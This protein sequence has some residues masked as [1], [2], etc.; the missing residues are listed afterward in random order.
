MFKKILIANRGEI[1]RR[2]NRTCHK[3]GIDTVA[4]YSDADKDA[5]FVREASEAYYIGESEAQ[6]SYLDV[7]KII[8]V[9]KQSGA[10]AVHPGYGFLSENANFKQSLTESNITFIG[11][12]HKALEIMGSK[13]KAKACMEAA[14]VPI[15][16]GYHGDNQDDAF[17]Q[18]QA[19]NI[20][21]PVLIKAVSGGGGKGMRV[22]E[23]EADFLEALAGAKRE[24]LNS[25]NDATVLLE[26]FL[27]TPRHIEVQVFADSHGNVVHLFERDCSVQRRHQKIIE[28]APAQNLSDK[29]LDT[30]Y[31]AAINAAKACDYLGAGTIE[32]LVEGENV[33]FMEMNTRLQ[34]EHPVTEMITGLD[35]VEWQLLV[36]NGALLPRAQEAITQSG[37]AIEVRLYAEDC[38]KDFLPQTGRV[39]YLRYPKENSH[40]R[41]DGG[42]VQGSEVSIYY[43]PMIAKLITHAD[44]REQAIQRM[45]QALKKLCLSGLTHNR[46]YLLKCLTHPAFMSGDVDIN[47][48]KKH[49][50]FEAPNQQMSIIAAAISLSL[51]DKSNALWQSAGPWRL[52]LPASEIIDLEYDN[53]KI[54][55][56][57][58]QTKSGYQVEYKDEKIELSAVDE[59]VDL[60]LTHPDGQYRCTCIHH[61]SK[62]TVIDA[63][64]DITFNIPSVVSKIADEDQGQLSAPM[65]GNVIAILCSETDNVEKGQSLMVIEAMKM[66]HTIKSP[67]TGKIDEIFFAIGAKVKEGDTLLSLVSNQ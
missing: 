47:F 30:L 32:F 48:I 4:V 16:P 38:D 2:I 43:D 6:K 59:G 55:V 8:A 9:A 10:D 15:T 20:G 28:E 25:F 62:I 65:P 63:I 26:K 19:K 53:K 7:D 49:G 3:L 60:T 29:V 44:S 21:Y 12:N 41:V 58:T 36:A 14:K 5:P 17:L 46:A 33:Y 57:L 64:Q 52:N 51:T 11:P 40:C 50:D 35:L 54:S 22:V 31:T 67:K 24:G 56:R 34:V 1:A 37:H 42:I 23:Q 39:N 27:I 18:S 66:E 45:V 13:S 61:D